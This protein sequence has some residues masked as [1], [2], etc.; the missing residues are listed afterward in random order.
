MTSEGKS[1]SLFIH[2]ATQENVKLLTK[3]P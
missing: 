2:T 3:L 1:S